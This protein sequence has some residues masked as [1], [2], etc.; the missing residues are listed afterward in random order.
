MTKLT[1]LFIFL[2]SFNS[3][4][5]ENGS[6]IDKYTDICSSGRIGTLI[7]KV[8]KAKSCKRVSIKKLEAL[9]VLEFYAKDIKEIPSET[10]KYMT[11]LKD[12][13]LAGNPISLIRKEAFAGLKNLKVL[14]LG[15]TNISEIEE[16]S[17][18]AL[19]SLT[20]I[21]LAEIKL[22]EVSLSEL[23]LKKGRVFGVKVIP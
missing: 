18:S 15:Y 23:G 10:F 3:Y 13:N 16:G 9:E 6:S 8:V 22:K 19:E 21:N 17:F 14:H 12:L 11:S 20:D 2:L 5:Q 4:T 7:A 1:I